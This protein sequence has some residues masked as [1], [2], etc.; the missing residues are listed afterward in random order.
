MISVLY[1]DDEAGL[2]E[3]A[4]LFLEKDGEFRVDTRISAQEALASPK[5]RSY[6]AIIADYQMPG[7]DGI[8]FL[9]VVREKFGDIPFI[10]FTGRGR[11]EVVIGAGREVIPIWAIT[12]TQENL[13]GRPLR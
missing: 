1:V 8:A 9:K 5:I 13:A 4:K 11:E 3:I 12:I 10:L 7:M 2:L 6:D